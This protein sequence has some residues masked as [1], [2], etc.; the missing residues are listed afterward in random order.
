VRLDVT[1]TLARAEV[2]GVMTSAVPASDVGNFEW[3]YVGLASQSDSVEAFYDDV[4]VSTVPV[5]CLPM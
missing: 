5:P 4:V 1:A 3:F 2:D